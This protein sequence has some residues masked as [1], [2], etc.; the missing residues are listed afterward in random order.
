MILLRDALLDDLEPL[1]AFHCDV[2]REA[3]RGIMPDTLLERPTL[4]E[5]RAQWRTV[6][7]WPVAD[8]L[9]LLARD[10]D[11]LADET[12]AGFVTGG[13]AADGDARFAAEI[14]G[15]YLGRAWRGGGTGAALLR[16]AADRLARSGAPDLVVWCL[17]ANTAAR[18][19]YRRMGGREYGFRAKQFYGTE[20]REVAYGWPDIALLRAPSDK[21]LPA[22]AAEG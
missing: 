22:L 16:A 18:G 7:D 11:G 5:R 4:P 2:W 14:Y 17:A 20:Q 13:P 6:L 12:I 8:R 10:S 3:Y 1:A 21:S 19:F 9:V 15:L